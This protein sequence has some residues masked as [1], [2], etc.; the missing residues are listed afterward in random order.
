MNRYRDL[1]SWPYNFGP[2]SE[3]KT[4]V[5]VLGA[6]PAGYVCA[7]RLAQLGKKVVCVESDE[8]GGTCLNW[9]C[10]PSK[11]LISAGHFME[12]TKH[13]AEMGF[14][15][16]EPSLDIDKLISWKDGI[17]SRLTGGIG[18]L[19]KKRGVEHLK[20]HGRIVSPKK[21]EVD[22]A[23]GVRTVL[24][25][26]IVVASGSEP[27]GIQ[28]FEFGPKVWSSTEALS[29]KSLPKELVIIGGGVIG[30]EL[31]MFYAQVGTD[32]TVIEYANQILPGTDSELVK[33]V[34]R[35]A[36]KAGMKIYVSASA[37]G[38]KEEAGKVNVDVE[39][40]GKAETFS[41][42][43][44]LLTTGRKPVTA[45]FGLNQVGVD[46]DER[47]FINVDA[48]SRTSVDSIYAI[49]DAT[50]GPMLAHKGSAQ[51]LVAASAIAGQLGS[52]W[53]YQVVPSVIFTD[54]EIATV[55][56]TEAE[57]K[58][59]GID[60]KVGRFNFSGNGRALSMHAAEGLVKVVT[61]AE[62]DV[63]IGVHMV[64]PSVTDMISE[65]ALAIE[66]GLTAE[67][68]ALTIHPH[69]TLSEVFMEACEDVHNLC[70][71]AAK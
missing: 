34:Q 56:L 49:G 55:G 3:I 16:G 48:N 31:G 23:E 66:S 40:K 15:V 9:G 11:A 46:L 5:V 62:D 58:E 21:V 54:P 24:A 25:T 37:K 60:C 50:N 51:G 57:A 6:G 61:R 32:V 65:A 33:V 53:D 4:D 43:Y 14:T 42:D 29:P 45:G 12:Q 27:S 26:D 64:G 67:D 28:G 8:L 18:M 30:M 17:V 19:F 13:A 38:W 44:I 2:M 47:G 69:P 41:G 7:I 22:T 36:K 10:I 52:G 71:H 35:K 1:A 63:L 59:K 70:I 39:V 68:I 20:G